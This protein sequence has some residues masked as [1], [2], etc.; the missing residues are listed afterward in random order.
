MAAGS[1]GEDLVDAA[2]ERDAVGEQRDVAATRRDEAGRDRDLLGAA[3]DVQSDARDTTG[4]RRD[5]AADERDRAAEERDRVAGA[6]RPLTGG[7]WARLQAAADRLDAASDRRAGELD[8][9]V[10]EADRAAS[11]DDREAAEAERAGS[12]RDR[13]DGNVDRVAAADDRVTA[14]IDDLTGARSRGAGLAELDREMARAER[15]SQ[16]L[17]LGYVDVDHLK[18]INDV[19]GHDAGDLALVGVVNAIRGVLRSYDLVVRLGGDEFLCVL[20]GL[21]EAGART[22]LADATAALSARD[23]PS[24]TVGIAQMRARESARALIARADADLRSR[25]VGRSGRDSA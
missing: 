10:S 1:E 6:E 18:R 19:D 3:R 12:E 20:A 23:L 14:T 4:H 11:L 17:T 13:I 16:P 24:A 5:I 7:E 25:R 8:R 21:D 9:S 2:S 22:R 15:T